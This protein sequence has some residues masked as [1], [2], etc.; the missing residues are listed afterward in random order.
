MGNPLTRRK[1]R[2]VLY[3]LSKIEFWD[4]VGEKRVDKLLFLIDQ[5]EDYLVGED[6]EC[7]YKTHPRHNEGIECTVCSDNE[8][9]QEQRQ[10]KLSNQHEHDIQKFGPSENISGTMEVC[11]TCGSISP[12]QKPNTNKD[13]SGKETK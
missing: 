12:N 6:E 1:I 5:H 2:N 4:E 13:S 7:K 8:F 11:M 3:N 10:R 9:R